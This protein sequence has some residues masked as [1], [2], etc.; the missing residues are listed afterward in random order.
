MTMPADRSILVTGV[1]GLLGRDVLARLLTANPRLRA[2]VLVRDVVR[3]SR[4]ARELGHTRVIPVQGDLCVEGLGLTTDVRAAICKDVTAIIHLA[5]NTSFSTPLDRARAVNTLGTQRVL[6]IANDCA[7]P[8]RV[9]YVSTAF[10]AGRRTGVI[11]EAVHSPDVGWVNAYE[12][13]KYEAEQLVRA[14]A[15]SWIIL[16]SSTVVCDDLGGRVTQ[17]NAVHRA[18]NLYRH[19]LVA[20]MPGV[21]GSTVDAVTTS[22]VADGIARLALRDDVTET[23]VHLCAGAGA[24]PLVELLDISYERWASDR[25]WRKRGIVR[26]IITDLPTYKLFERTIEDVAEPSLKRIARAL[27]HFVPQLALPKCFDTTNAEALLGRAAP[28]VRDF[29]LPMLDHMLATQSVASAVARVA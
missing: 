12:Q 17:M 29:W 26:P 6:D 18:L 20:M 27:S 14:Q 2:Y 1:T 19:G 10:V 25:S 3:W 22:F 28:P 4:V 21:V 7:S 5:A 8:A 24:L 11:A 23:V 16:R 9:V 15:S 13:S